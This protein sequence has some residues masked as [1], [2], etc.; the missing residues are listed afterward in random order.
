[1]KCLNSLCGYFREVNQQAS[2]VAPNNGLTVV[3]SLGQPCGP[4]I[5][6]LDKHEGGPKTRVYCA[7]VA[8]RV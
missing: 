3:R 5:A 7:S 4:G 6:A 2:L 1:M 8:P